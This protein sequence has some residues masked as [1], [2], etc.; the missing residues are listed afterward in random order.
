ME[1]QLIKALALSEASF[2][3]LDEENMEFN[4]Q[5]KEIIDEVLTTINKLKKHV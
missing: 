4:I 2:E 5:I 1:K 3:F